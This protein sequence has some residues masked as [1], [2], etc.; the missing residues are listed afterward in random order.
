MAAG[1]EL[2]T[3]IKRARERRHWRQA[4]LA[5]AI[6]VNVKTVGNWERGHT[7]PRNRIG[8][9][10]A[11]LGISLTE[12]EAAE[13]SWYD[14]DDPIERGIAEDPRLPEPVR[15]DFVAQLRAKRLEHVP[16]A[17]HAPRAHEPPA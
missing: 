16:R 13:A 12:D 4:D 9:I 15:R 11:T 8:A 1:T 6:G 17:E 5:R 14:P 7:I 10:E 3:R 2:G